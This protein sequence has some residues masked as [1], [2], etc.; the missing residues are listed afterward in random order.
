MTSGES[1]RMSAAERPSEA[2][3]AEQAVRSNQMSR[4]SE[5]TEEAGGNGSVMDERYL[6]M[7][8]LWFAV[9]ALQRQSTSTKTGI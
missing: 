3:S 5:R 8:S 6:Q 4:A 1:E 9:V 7:T 2:D